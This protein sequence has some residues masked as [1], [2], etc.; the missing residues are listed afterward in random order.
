MPR[1]KNTTPVN[2][3]SL[4]EEINLKDY[5]YYRYIPIKSIA[6]KQKKLIRVEVTPIAP[7][8]IVQKNQTYA[9]AVMETIAV[10]PE[11]QYNYS[12]E[13]ESLEQRAL[14]VNDDIQKG[15]A[16]LYEQQQECSANQAT[17]QN[18]QV[19][20]DNNTDIINKQITAYNHNVNVLSQQT[21]QVN[22]MNGQIHSLNQIITGLHTDITNKHNELGAAQKHLEDIQNQIAYHGNML[23]AFNTIMQNPQYFIQ[24]M[25]VAS[26]YIYN[27]DTI[28]EC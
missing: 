17:I 8:S 10:T 4:D 25:S 24:M 28:Y 6:E 26:E 9:E 23:N 14:E 22:I 19:A 18:Q 13:I 12:A 3:Y 7:V 15:L 5:P 2:N 1:G 21:D 11:E 27:Q 16:T 20:I